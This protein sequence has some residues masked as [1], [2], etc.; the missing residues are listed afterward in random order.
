MKYLQIIQEV[1]AKRA[2][3]HYLG[4]N[5]LVSRKLSDFP[6]AGSAIRWYTVIESKNEHT[7]AK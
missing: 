5:G 1:K 3:L 2:C 4:L 6:S 7:L